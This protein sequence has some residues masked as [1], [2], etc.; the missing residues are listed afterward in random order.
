MRI[1]KRDFDWAVEHGLIAAGPAEALWRGLEAH[2]AQ[3]PKF[4][5][6]HVAYYA[7]ALIIILA[8]AWFMTEAWNRFGATGLLALA[9]AYGV[10]FAAAGAGLWNQPG[11]RIPGGLLVTVAVCMTPLAVFAIEWLAGMWPS[12]DEKQLMQSYLEYHAVVSQN[13]VPMEIATIVVA[14]IALWFFRFPFLVMPI[15]V[16]LYYLATDIVPM[17]YGEGGYDWMDTRWVSLCFGLTVLA[18]AYLVDRRSEEDYA[19]WLYLYGG[20]TFWYGLSYLTIERSVFAEQPW[21]T[22][23]HLYALICVA[24]MFVSVLLQ[25][26]ALI[27][28]GSLGVVGY[29][30]WLA[31]DVFKDSLIFPFLLTVVGLAVIWA[32][33]QYHKHQEKLDRMVVENLP[34]GFVKWLPAG[35]ARKR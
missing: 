29:L 12:V 24:L 2:A 19:F 13:Y 31:W 7:G 3:R 4:D 21:A 5:L 30:C 25:R 6:P 32:G 28:Y 11:Q 1:R 23:M 9:I 18:A 8:M 34:A 10:I 33:I 14:L 27:V 20:L 17:L 15:A 26:R 16:S 22:G 35:R